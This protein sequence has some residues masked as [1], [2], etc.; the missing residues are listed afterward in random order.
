MVWGDVFCPPS[1]LAAS[2]YQACMFPI[3]FWQSFS[4]F[5][6]VP[7]AYT[8]LGW[9]QEERWPLQE[10]PVEHGLMHP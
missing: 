9:E 10:M 1:F 5:S 3:A 7:F 2:P 6:P 8:T 4:L